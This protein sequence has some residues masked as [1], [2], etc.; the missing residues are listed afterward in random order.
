[1]KF[2][3]SGEVMADVGD[4]FREAINEIEDDLNAR[5]VDRNY[6]SALD[7]LS[8]IAIIRPSGDDAYPEIFKYDKKRRTVEARLKVNHL[9]FRNARN[10]EDRK[11]LLL[12]AIERAIARMGELKMDGDHQ[13]L[14]SDF[15][16]LTGA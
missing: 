15:Q 2:W 9:D 8:F 7:K 14:L 16:N 13:R 10:N 5:F 6:G 4:G 3:F 12:N 1:M 11:R